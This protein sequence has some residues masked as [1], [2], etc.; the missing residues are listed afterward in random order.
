MVANNP[1]QGLTIVVTVKNGDR[2]EGLLSGSNPQNGFS[3]ITLKMV[4]KSHAAQGNGSAFLE[5][6]FIGASPDHALN[7]DIKEITDVSI[8]EFATA[9]STKAA[10]GMPFPTI[11]FNPISTA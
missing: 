8:P 6:A 7:V 2:F 9:Q 4:R 11:T 10:N 1:C 5:A 3:K